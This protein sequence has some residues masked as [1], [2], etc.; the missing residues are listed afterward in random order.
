MSKERNSKNKFPLNNA[1]YIESINKQLSWVEDDRNGFSSQNLTLKE[2]VRKIYLALSENEF[3]KE[4]RKKGNEDIDFFSRISCGIIGIFLTVSARNIADNYLWISESFLFY[5][6]MT[7]LTIFLVI[8]L[9]RVS[10]VKA[11]WEYSFV[12][13]S[14]SIG[15]AGLLLYCNSESSSVINSIFGV[16]ASVFVYSKSILTGLLLLKILSPIFW[17]VVASSLIQFVVFF[18]YLRKDKVLG[19]QFLYAVSA[20]LL[21]GYFLNVIS[22]SLS[23]NELEFKAYKLA[24]YLDF[25]EKIYC[26]DKLPNIERVVGVYLSPSNDVVLLDNKLEIEES[27]KSFMHRS[28]IDYG[29][30]IPEEFHVINCQKIN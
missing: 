18:L 27:A 8:S 10:L 19:R 12:K 2:Y 15:F 7:L 13:F 25:N 9:E 30:E 6:G 29:I 11:L 5:L 21:S 26:L 23:D 4:K 3:S 28:F 16:D 20:F 24:H 1:E 22:N 17:V 14:A